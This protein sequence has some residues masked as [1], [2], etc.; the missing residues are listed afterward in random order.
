[1]HTLA[2]IYT[3][4]ERENSLAKCSWVCQEPESLTLARYTAFLIVST[5]S[6][7]SGCTFS[8]CTHILSQV[9]LSIGKPLLLTRKSTPPSLSSSSEPPLLVVLT[10]RAWVL[11]DRPPLAPLGWGQWWALEVEPVMVGLN[12][13]SS[14]GGAMYTVQCPNKEA[15]SISLAARGIRQIEMIWAH[16]SQ[17]DQCWDCCL[18]GWI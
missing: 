11:L 13:K 2:C 3:A 9:C 7:P 6:L 10:G 12:C 15:L 5:I 16:R 1:M 17:C 8:T 18:V 4:G 14:P